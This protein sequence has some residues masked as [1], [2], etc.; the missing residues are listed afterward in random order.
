M[1]R[2]L[3]KWPAIVT[4]TVDFI[5]GVLAVGLATILAKHFDY[6]RLTVDYIAAIGVVIGHIFPLYFGFKGGKGVITICGAVLMI[7]WYVIPIVL[8]IFAI[9]VKLTKYVSLG[10]I[11]ATSAF[12]FVVL[13]ANLI[14]NVSTSLILIEFGLGIAFAGIVIAK[15]Y[16]NIKRL[17]SHSERKLGEPKQ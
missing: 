2:N 15:H 17:L 16:E 8:I 6:D 11:L 14:N 3:G 5:K 1:L 10:S 7:H 12:P 9:V 13:I 4:L